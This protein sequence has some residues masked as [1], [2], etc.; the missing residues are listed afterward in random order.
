MSQCASKT[1][2]VDLNAYILDSFSGRI[3][4]GSLEYTGD[5]YCVW[6]ISPVNS[7]QVVLKF[8]AF[9]LEGPASC[10][11]GDYVEIF[12]CEDI[13]CGGYMLNAKQIIR[14]SGTMAVMPSSI[15]SKTGIMRINFRTDAMWSKKGFEASYFS[16]CEAGTYGNGKPNCQ[17]CT[18][19][20]S[21]DKSLV[22]TSCGEIGSTK[23]NLCVCRS[24]H[25]S[26]DNS[27][28]CL[29]CPVKC[30]IGE[31]QYLGK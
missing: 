10:C 9:E 17:K 13:L 29:P 21:S 30:D 2:F 4:V 14:I 31:L 28:L 5:V 8:S 19:S 24:G 25:F 26:T 15:V 27:D 1:F 12:E 22:I 23:D 7:T 16:P 6:I 20:C 3:S 11:K 18:T